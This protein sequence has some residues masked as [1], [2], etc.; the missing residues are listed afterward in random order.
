MS[1]KR[2][3]SDERRISLLE[4]QEKQII[5]KIVDSDL[6]LKYIDILNTLHK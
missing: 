2:I 1:K 3:Q 4:E 5:Q 6:V